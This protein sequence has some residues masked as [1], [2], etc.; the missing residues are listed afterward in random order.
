MLASLIKAGVLVAGVSGLV[1]GSGVG[2]EQ[3]GWGRAVQALGGDQTTNTAL[4]SA[5]AEWK[6][7]Q[8][9]PNS[10]FE[11]YARFLIAHPGWPSELSLRRNAERAM[12]SGSWSPSTAVSFFRRFPPLSSTAK[13]RFA[14]ALQSTGARDEAFLAAHAAWVSGN[15]PAADES[16]MLGA[17]ASEFSPADQ[18]ARMDMLLWQNATAAA[19]RQIAYV[20]PA[21]RALFEARLAF[22]TKAPDA[23]DRFAATQT[24]GSSDAGYVADR[25]VYLRNSGD[26]NGVRAW[27]ARPHSFATP[28]A[29]ADAW[30][31]IL[32]TNARGAAADAQYSTAFAIAR[33][34]DDAYPA[35]T[36]VSERPYAERDDYTSLAWLAGQTALKQLGR[37]GDASTMFLRYASASKTPT[38]QSKGFYW[39]GRAAE[40]SGRREEANGYFT[41][42]SGFRDLFYGQL[43]AERLGQPLTAP[44]DPV[45]RPV[46]VS[47]RTGFYNRETVRAAQYL[48]T[49][50]DWEDQTAFVR[51]IAV[52]AKTDSDHV[53]AT[54]LSRSLGRPDLG[55]MVGRSA[56]QNGLSDYS[57]V[58]YPTVRIPASANDSW[59]MVHAISRQESQFD[60]GAVSHAGARGLMQLM[61][62]TAR[63][64]STKLGMS[65]N[66]GSLTTD[67]DYNVM[68]GAAYFQRIYNLYG[69]YPLAVAAYNAGPGNVNK[70]LA[71]NGDPRQGADIVDW[72]EAIP[73]YE[74]KN[75]VQRVLENAVVYDLMNPQHSRS[76][77]TARLSWYLGKGRPG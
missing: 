52:D 70:W 56:L 37:P 30:F 19:Q 57:T 9:S 21:K 22:R 69:S 27:L 42:A 15:L 10:P 65:Y 68:L 66:A 5:I 41:R 17:F 50:G 25:A 72:I 59:T 13:A 64:T 24:F 16:A 38:T 74:T 49:V 43:A 33:Q 67:T 31:E 35:G 51:Q 26:A 61:P 1:A 20:S 47:V 76:T 58:G 4:S 40:Q 12:D 6:S 8:Q 46:D 3:L 71:A 36:D 7:L 14:V 28:P 54:E 39:A 44:G 75:Y 2:Q 48:G 18:D 32:L 23:E 29:D 62:G 73:I 11:S 60:R 55:V 34:L 77:G 45:M 53:L 63:E